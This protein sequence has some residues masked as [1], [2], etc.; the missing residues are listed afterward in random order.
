MGYTEFHGIPALC[1]LPYELHS[2]S[3]ERQVCLCQ[4]PS[5]IAA[6]LQGLQI[7]NTG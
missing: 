6:V 1:V 5:M 3:S 4:F 2:V 7:P